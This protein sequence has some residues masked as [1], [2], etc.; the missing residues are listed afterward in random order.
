[1]HKR[2]ETL[3]SKVREHH[4]KQY[5]QKDSLNPA[6]SFRQKK[7]SAVTRSAER[8]KMLLE[9]E[10][11]HIFPEERIA[12]IRTV[13]TI[14]P[15]F[16]DDEWNQISSSHFICES[17]EVFNICSDYE[18]LIAEGI[19]VRKEKI[20]RILS[21]ANQGKDTAGVEFLEAA[22]SSL[23]AVTAFVGRYKEEAKK[24][25]NQ[26]IFDTLSQ[27][28]E[29]GARTLLEALQ[30]FRI[31]NYVLWINGNYH[32]TIGRFDQY[33]YPY[34]LHDIERGILTEEEAY[35]LIMEIFLALN[36]DSYLYKGVQQGDNGQS[37]VLGGCDKNGKPAFNKLTELCLK[38]S[39]EI[40]MID[41]KI[42]LRVSRDTP[43]TWFI[44]GTE[45]TKA[46]LG[47]PQYSNDD[48]II[49]AL[50]NWGYELEDARN[51]VTAAC[52]EFIIPGKG[53]DIPNI[54]A[55]NL[56]EILN[57]IVHDQ[58]NKIS[59]FEELKTKF[60]K[61]LFDK[62]ERL[63]AAHRDLY[64]VPSPFQ[65]VCMNGCIENHRDISEGGKYNNYGIHGSGISTVVDSLYCLKKLV[66][67]A[68]EISPFMMTEMLK[69]NYEGFEKQHSKILDLKKMGDNDPELVI[70]IEEVIDLFSEAFENKKNERGG[71]YRPGTGTAMYYIWHAESLKA[72]PDGRKEGQPFPANFS[73][74]LLKR[75]PGFLSVIKAFAPANITK[76]ANGGPLTIEV[77]NTVFRNRQGIEKTAKL[78]QFFIEIGGH[79]LQINTLDKETLLEAQLHPE[80]YKN[81]IVRVWG[82]S[83][84]FIELDREFQ[85][86]II[87]RNEYGTIATPDH[88]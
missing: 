41:P 77:H 73:P 39:L 81:L 66:Y 44:Q 61:S 37:I 13:K 5:L 59:T 20:L 87:K 35:E 31:I 34:F 58:L 43:E 10:T 57:N 21:Q 47:F 67:E 82:W 75:H 56:P 68:G 18:S 3:M 30:F 9:K 69:K 2:I 78:V 32:N 54:D 17:G 25:N 15:L 24:I 80:D 86:H 12:L 84:Y 50:T 51:Y 49:K 72:T 85:D 27:V 38:A 79:Q 33:M 1:M 26:E 40:E 48:V 65:S 23:Q 28:P 16:T 76:A 8:L 22:Y 52:W 74:S 55:V 6:P 60:K 88:F 36:K 4:Y 70:L 45:L 11:P 14:P 83:G 29:H 53:M 71:C 63:T 46:G 64:I 19:G 7:Y 62:V 42:N